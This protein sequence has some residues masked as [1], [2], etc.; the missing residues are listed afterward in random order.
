M[1]F[2]GAPSSYVAYD[3][4][5]QPD[6]H[7]IDSRLQQRVCIQFNGRVA[8]WLS[9]RGLKL[10][11]DGLHNFR[12]QGSV[13]H[14]VGSLLPPRYG[15]ARFAQVYI[16]DSDM[17]A[18]VACR[19]QITDVLDPAILRKIDQVTAVHN[20]YTQQVLNARSR[21]VR[22]AGP[23]YEAALEELER[24]R[25]AAE[26]ILEDDLVLRLQDYIP[27]DDDFRLRLHVAWNANPGTHRV[28]SGSNCN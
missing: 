5:R 22:R 13:C 20:E 9:R 6:V 3:A 28:R 1:R 14:R 4:L 8:I 18:R 16:N 10:T 12:E 15:R 7:A 26:D 25:A 11:R 27:P 23:E 17:E 2:P 19:M 24:R 21:L